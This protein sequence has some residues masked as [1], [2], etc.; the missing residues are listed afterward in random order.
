MLR[1]LYSLLTIALVLHVTF[2]S[3]PSAAQASNPSSDSAS[4]RQVVRVE[5]EGLRD[6]LADNVRART[7]L[8]S[9]DG[10]PAP[11]SFRL[12][13]LQRR[14]ENEIREALMP[15]GYYQPII[16]SELEESS[17]AWTIRFEVDAGKPVQLTAVSVQVLGAA[18]EDPRFIELKQR[19]PLKVGDVLNH[20]NYERAKGQLRNL[21]AERGYYDS[22]FLAHHVAV[23]LTDQSA[24]ID[25]TLDSGPR[26]HYGKIEFCCAHISDELLQRYIQFET[27]DP[28]ST[29]EL[30]NLQLGLSSSNYFETIEIAPN[31]SER[32]EGTVP[33]DVTMTPNQRDHYQVGLGYGTD[34]GARVTLG[35]DRRWVNDR[36]HHINSILRLSEVQ[37][38][39]SVSYIIPGFYPPTDQYDVT[40]EVTDRSYLEQRSTLY[41]LAGRDIRHFDDWQRTW[42]LSWQRE[43]FAF[44][45]EPKRSSQFLIPAAEF[46]L[47]R[48][49]SNGDN[50]NLIDDGY[51]VSLELR[52][53]SA[54]ILADTTFFSAR[55]SGKWVHRFSSN[56]RI[57]TRGEIGAIETDDFEKL[58]PSLRFFAGGD[59]SVRGYAYQDLGPRNEEDVVI[60]GRYIVTSSLEV[61]YQI[62]DAWR[63][64]LFTDVGNA[65]MDWDSNLKQSIGFGVRWLS[66]IGPVRLDLAQAIDEPGNPWRIH[67]TLGPD[68]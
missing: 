31:W 56:W 49:T 48:S 23:E 24:K 3:S 18:S 62:N 63:V 8:F 5:L 67:F 59:Y 6:E 13:F 21:A 1:R 33:V 34:T 14:A 26:Y 19:L 28:F 10:Q 7:T 30:L 39:G 53:A 4:E 65:M 50:R 54:D 43:R 15:Y 47:I 64:A 61:D 11:A 36:G 35:F 27:G 37:N 44:G 46:S 57:L 68:L 22:E 58:S 17:S 2:S 40:A 42:Q 51:R 9:L 29:S 38:T 55:L 60:G 20:P 12:R 16:E 25:L 52:G 41:R 32:S 45:E 66:P